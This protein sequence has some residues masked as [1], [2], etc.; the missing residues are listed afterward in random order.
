M[1]FIQI[2]AADHGCRIDDFRYRR[3]IFFYLAGCLVSP[4]QI[5]VRRQL[6]GDAEAAFIGLGH[7][8]RGVEARRDEGYG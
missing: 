4:F 3:Q 2:A 8:F 6:E 5:G 7:E 1:G